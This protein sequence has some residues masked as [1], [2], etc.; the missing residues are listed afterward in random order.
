MKKP[1]VITRIAIISATLMLMLMFAFVSLPGPA[2]AADTGQTTQ[3]TTTIGNGVNSATIDSGKITSPPHAT[4]PHATPAAIKPASCTIGDPPK[5]AAMAKKLMIASTATQTPAYEFRRFIGYSPL[6][7]AI[8]HGAKLAESSI[9]KYEEVE[10]IPI[11]LKHHGE[12]RYVVYSESGEMKILPKDTPQPQV[13]LAA[14]IKSEEK[15]ISPPATSS[16]K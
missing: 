3:I 10:R 11:L 14:I 9:V 8:K 4:A 13:F 5:D 12:E 2:Y 16:T 7:L 15:L 1:P 6:E